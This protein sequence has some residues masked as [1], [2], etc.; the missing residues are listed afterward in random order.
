MKNIYN[1][2]FS[3]IKHPG[4][5]TKITEQH[6][7][8]QINVTSACAQCH[9]QSMCKAFSSTNKTIEFNAADYPDLK[10]GQ[11]VNILMR[12]ELGFKALALGYI[13]PA[14][15]LIISIFVTFYFFR[16]DLYASVAT[17]VI[18]FSYYL[19]LATQK[20]KLK[21]NFSFVLEA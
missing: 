11:Q 20:N 2:E 15:L 5:V 19:I 12:K 7:F 18:L 17:I 8:V 3:I 16:N 21:K 9:A 4:V 10:E 14:F 1:S 6:I 13:F